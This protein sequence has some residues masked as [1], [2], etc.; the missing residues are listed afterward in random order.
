LS[1]IEQEEMKNLKASKTIWF[2]LILSEKVT[3]ID[4]GIEE[5]FID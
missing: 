4:L 2:S 5:S 1:Q 3:Q